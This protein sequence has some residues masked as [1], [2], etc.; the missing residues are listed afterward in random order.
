[1]QNLP[2]N[3]PGKFYRGNLHTHSTVSDGL[4]SIE[5]VCAFYKANGYHF[6]S[7]TDHFMKQFDYQIADPR[8]YDSAD[9]VSIIGAELHS[10]R[11]STGELWHILANGLPLDF[12]PPTEDE[13]GPQIAQR[14]LDAG[15]LV[16][17]AHPAWYALTEADVLSLGECHAI[18]TI[19]G[20]SYDHN[21]R[22]DSW[23]MLD[24]MLARGYRYNALT[25]DD[26]HFHA[27]H[28]DRLKGWVWV[29]TETLSS[30][31][32]LTALKAGEYYC[33]SGPQIFDLEIVS[34]ESITIRCSPVNS[35]FITGAGPSSAYQHGN[36]IIETTLSLERVKGDYC[37]VTI[38][39]AQGNRAWTNPI[40][41]D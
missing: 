8:P 3:K 36:G 40:W 12:A 14:A 6:L 13:T 35:I 33:S 2:F 30:D 41:F 29:K 32:L 27:F 26:A 4:K 5:E 18:E 7:I 11:T 31:A 9:F 21:D 19:N 25:T 23:Y 20:I 38:R 34:R 10:G 24:V 16:T 1:M 28:N 39:D 37:R 15:A 17:V 22:V